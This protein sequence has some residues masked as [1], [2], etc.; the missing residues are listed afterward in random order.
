MPGFWDAA[1]TEA[2]AALR[3]R[4]APRSYPRGQ[5]LMYAGQMPS[6]VLLLEAGWV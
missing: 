5:A 3:A 1:G 4:M 2:A 6:E